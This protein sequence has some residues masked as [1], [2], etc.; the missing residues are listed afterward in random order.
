M[1]LDSRLAEFI[2]SSGDGHLGPRVY[3]ITVVGGFSDLHFIL[4]HVPEL[5]KK[6]FPKIKIH[7]FKA[8]TRNCFVCKFYSKDI[9][10]KLSEYVPVGQKD[11]NSTKIPNVIS[12]DPKLLKRCICGLIDTD[13]G[14]YSHHKR[15][16]QIEYSCRSPSLQKS[17]KEGLF[18]LG[19]NPACSG[20]SLFLFNKDVHKY[21]AE[22]G[23]SNLKH[24]MKYTFWA[25]KHRVMRTYE[26]IKI[27]WLHIKNESLFS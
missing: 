18:K 24:N 25:K 10:L 14:I 22:I 3:E 7:L 23:S 8:R 15:S 11:K 6:L 4:V 26:I 27:V 1:K 21:F 19:F 5:I 20:K 13:G 9:M 17:V 12:E 16:A 2:G